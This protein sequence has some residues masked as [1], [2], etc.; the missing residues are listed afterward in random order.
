MATEASNVNRTRGG[1][2]RDAIARTA[3][4][5]LDEEGADALSMRRLATRLGVGTMTLYGYFRSKQE[6]LDAAVAAAAAEVEIDLPAGA[7]LREKLRAHATAT[8]RMLERH[9]GLPQ[10]R[11]RQPLVQAPAFA[12]TEVAMQALLDAG[13]PPDE[14][15]RV[16]RVLFVYKF[17]SAI[18]GRQDTPPEEHRRVRAAL[19]LLPEDEFPAVTAAADGIAASIGGTEQFAFGLELILDAIEARAARYSAASSHQ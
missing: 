11:A 15:A 2:D 13:F 14:A 9:P 4:Q 12:M 3:L 8:Q 5:L 19:H 10:L 1:I 7:G 6:L 18:V 17:G 16:F